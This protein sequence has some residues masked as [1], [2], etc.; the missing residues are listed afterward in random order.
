MGADRAHLVAAGRLGAPPTARQ[1]HKI[2]FSSPPRHAFPMDHQLTSAH[3]SAFVAGDGYAEVCRRVAEEHRRF[4]ACL[5]A[6]IKTYSGRWL[7]FRDGTVWDAC[8]SA[9]EA[10]IAAVCRFGVDGAFVVE[11]VVPE[12]VAEIAEIQIA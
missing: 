7:V 2:A 1:D 11:E 3:A 8:G 12:G 9:D 10:H 5:P 6:L 4:L